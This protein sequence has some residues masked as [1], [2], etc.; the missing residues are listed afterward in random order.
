MFLFQ[1]AIIKVKNNFNEAQ[2]DVNGKFSIQAEEGNLLRASYIG[3]EP[4]EQ[5]LNKS[6]QLTLNLKADAEILDEVHLEDEGELIK[7][8]DLGF[9][10]KKNFDAIG[11]DVKTMTSKDIKPHN[12][13]LLDLLTGKFCRCHSSRETQ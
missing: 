13:N 7:T 4:Q 2:T 6:T 12:Y 5:V 3:T 10:G 8:I 1:G 11:Y 9:N